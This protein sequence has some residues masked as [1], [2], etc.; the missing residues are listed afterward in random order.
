[1]P[2]DDQ[3]TMKTLL[4]QMILEPDPEA[5]KRIARQVGRQLGEDMIAR[6][7]AALDRVFPVNR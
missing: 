5:R 1:M 7:N 6:M 3:P 4:H 2:N